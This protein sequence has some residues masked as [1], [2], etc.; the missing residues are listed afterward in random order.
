MNLEE[1]FEQVERD[2]QHHKHGYPCEVVRGTAKWGDKQTNP[3]ESILKVEQPVGTY[4]NSKIYKP[5]AFGPLFES[6]P[7]QSNDYYRKG[8]IEVID[9]I[10]A[11]LTPEQYKGY[12]LGNIYKYS[13]RCQYKGEYQKDIIKL[14]QYTNWLLKEEDGSHP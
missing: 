1:A 5:G 2:E 13:G 12:L 3:V 14:A 9:F 4:D 7:K 6:K 11:K 10:K 8:G